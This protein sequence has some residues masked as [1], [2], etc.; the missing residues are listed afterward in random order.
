MQGISRVWDLGKSWSK[1]DWICCDLDG[2]A[3]SLEVGPD[4]L[5]VDLILW[6]CV[7][8]WIQACCLGGRHFYA[9][10]RISVEIEILMK[11][12]TAWYRK[13]VKKTVDRTK[14]DPLCFPFCQWTG[15][16]V[17]S[18]QGFQ[19]GPGFWLELYLLLDDKI[20]AG[21]T[22]NLVFVRWWRLPPFS[23]GFDTMIFFL[24]TVIQQQCLVFCLLVFGFNGDGLDL[25]AC[26][27]E[28]LF[29]SCHTAASMTGSD[30]CHGK[31]LNIATCWHVWKPCWDGVRSCL[32][33]D[34]SSYALTSLDVFPSLRNLKSE[35]F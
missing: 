19:L 29:F 27:P 22:A 1:R 26:L 17:S 4:D 33:R 6:F 34:D 32:T 7:D 24:P 25:V 11:V 9:T 8:I 35:K 23:L 14:L 13:Q 20:L 3:L 12:T 2:P 21:I 30:A 15:Q 31:P 18:P 10:E 5:S 16:A 28:N